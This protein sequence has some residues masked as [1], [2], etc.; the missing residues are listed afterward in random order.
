MRLLSQV[1]RTTIPTMV[2]TPKMTQKDEVIS[3][4]KRQRKYVDGTH[5]MDEFGPGALRS[6][7]RARSEGTKITKRKMNDGTWQ[8]KFG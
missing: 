3:F 8:Y 4:L 1:R 5:L 7:R 2:E 6:L